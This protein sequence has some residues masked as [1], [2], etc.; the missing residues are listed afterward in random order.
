M[1]DIREAF[2]A[3][4]A[5]YHG[6]NNMTFDH[7]NN[8]YL[9]QE[10]NYYWLAFQAGQEAALQSQTAPSVPEEETGKV[11][12]GEPVGKAYAYAVITQ[13]GDIDHIIAVPCEALD[14]EGAAKQMCRNHIEA[15]IF[16]DIEGA[17]TWVIRPLYTHPAESREEIQAQALETYAGQLDA[18]FARAQ[19]AGA[20][21]CPAWHS[22]QFAKDVQKQAA[23]LRASQQEGGN[24][25]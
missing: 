25:E 6:G 3:H 9:C 20:D 8:Y 11:V 14:P 23:R 7:S 1:S 10:V 18:V 22:G 4:F 19:E 24:D 5:A 17:E 13:H 15:A 2:E 12:Q 16:A 21:N